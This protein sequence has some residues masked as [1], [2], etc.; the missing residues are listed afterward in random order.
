LFLNDLRKIVKRGVGMK[1]L[2][3]LVLGLSLLVGCTHYVTINPIEIGKEYLPVLRDIDSVSVV[4]E[5]QATPDEY[6]ICADQG[7]KFYA[8]LNQITQT[9]VLVARDVLV[10]NNITVEDEASKGLKIS[11]VD[12]TCDRTGIS[13]I[14]CNIFIKAK[15]GGDIEREFRGDQTL[16]AS[17]NALP[18]SYE[19]ETVNAV[20][21]MFRDP[22]II[23]YLQN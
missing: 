12:A 7:Q 15:T 18:W 21:E 17:W 2:I 16:V 20:T 10:Q 14:R 3:L 1:K 4:G 8:N 13:S 23:D 6:L 19:A 11:V 5:I 22:D 9:A